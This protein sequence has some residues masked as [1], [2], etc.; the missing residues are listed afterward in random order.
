M[1]ETY[2]KES[3]LYLPRFSAYHV[4]S[5]FLTFLDDFLLF[6]PFCLENF[7]QPFFKVGLLVANSFSVPLSRMGLI[8]PLFLKNIFNEYK[9]IVDSAFLSTPK[10]CATFFWS[11]LFLMKHLLMRNQSTFQPV[12]KGVFLS[13]F[14]YFFCLQFSEV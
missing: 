2:K 13:C 10:K 4:L 11:P 5:S 6:F 9:T 1:Q 12:R 14:S 8:S 7:L 3:L